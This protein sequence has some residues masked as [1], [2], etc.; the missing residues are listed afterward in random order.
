[1]ALRASNAPWQQVLADG[2][3][4]LA[5]DVDHDLRARLRGLT[6]LAE[7]V[8][9]RSDPRSSWA[10]FEAWLRRQVADAAVATYDYLLERAADLT[11]HVGRQFSQDAG[12]P[13]A[14]SLAA[15]LSALEDVQLG[16]R[17]QTERG[18][19]ATMALTAGRG[20]YG[21][22][23]MFGMAGSLIGLPLVA[24]VALVLS[25]GLAR[26]ALR[27]DLSRRHQARQQQAKAAMRQYLD[28]VSFVVNKECRDALRR[29]Q[30]LLRDEFTG[31]A[32]SLHRSSTEALAHAEQA[33]RLGA[34]ERE[35]RRR[36]LEGGLADLAAVGSRATA[37]LGVSGAA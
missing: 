8:I 35:G 16:G 26:K 9:D 1:V 37:A 19:R 22:M 4:D 30:R 25:L 33:L 17:F 5:S 20:A 12:A 34:G 31:R 7:D 27:D 23:L 11:E 36:E 32:Q 18:A 13:I 14:F 24:P 3:Q 21:G 10:E 15:P 6:R 29:T 28:E 2:I